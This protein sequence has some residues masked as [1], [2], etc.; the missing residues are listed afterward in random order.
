ME[1]RTFEEVPLADAYEEASKR[2]TACGKA[3][4]DLN[5]PRCG[6]AMHP[7]VKQST[8]TWR[9]SD[10]RCEYSFNEPKC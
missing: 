2:D 10:N 7:E 8:Y 3:L 1:K 9:C 5:C 4:R 6:S